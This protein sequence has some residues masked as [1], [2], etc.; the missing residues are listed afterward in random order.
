[1][2][3]QRFPRTA[4][5]LRKR[6]F[7]RV[8]GSPL[9]RSGEF[10]RGQVLANAG[11]QA[12]LGLA[13]AKRAV[14]ASVDRNRLRRIARETFRILRS[15]LGALDCVIGAKP[16]AGEIDNARLR[17]DLERLLRRLAALNPPSPPGTITG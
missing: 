10:F 3:A 7:D 4:R 16:G 15:E 17:A 11:G 5:L 1:L 12:R 13:I 6:E 8:F 14:P 9:R 2:A